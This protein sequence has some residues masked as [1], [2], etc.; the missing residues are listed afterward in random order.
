MLIQKQHLKNHVRDNIQ[1]INLLIHS[2]ALLPLNLSI[3]VII[4]IMFYIDYT[5]VAAIF[6]THSLKSRFFYFVGEIP[7]GK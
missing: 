7:L 2:S 1:T 3:H 6:F 4:V 5:F